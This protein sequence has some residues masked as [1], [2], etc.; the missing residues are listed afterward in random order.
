VNKKPDRGN[1]LRG[2]AEAQLAR[3]PASAQP[4]PELLHELQVHQ[5]EL[6]MQNESLRQAQIALEKSRDRYVDLY[7]FAPVGFLTATSDGLIAKVNLT[8]TA[9]L[10]QERKKLLNHR[11]DLQ[12]MPEDRDRW[13]RQAKQALQS[14]AKHSC[15]LALKRGDGQVLHALADYQRTEIGDAPALRVALTDISQRRQAEEDLRIAAIAFESEEGMMVADAH[16]VIIRV[17]RAF[18]TLTGFSAQEVLGKTPALLRSD[19]HDKAFYDAMWQALRDK[20]YWQGEVWNRHKNG[21]LC[22]VW[23]TI[24][25]VAAPDGSVSHYVGSFSDIT[26]NKLAADEIFQLAY[27]DPLTHLANRRRLLDRLGQALTNAAETGRLGAILFLD[28][29]NFKT[30]NDTRGHDSGDLLLTE[31]AQRMRASVRAGDTLA[32]LG[33]DEFVVLL[34]NLSAHHGEAA[35]LANQVGQKL[36]QSL[37]QPY[38]LKDFEYHG[39]VSIGVGLFQAQDTVE[40]L[41]K[42]AD[43]ALYQAK[44]AGRNT[45]RFFDP[46]M[47]AALDARSA[48]EADLRQALSRQELRLYYQPQIDRQGRVVGAEA[49]IRWQHPQR[50]LVLPGEFIG[51]A[52]DC[53]LIVPIGLWVLDCACA[54]LRAWQGD[55]LMKTLQL[56]VNV[57]AR[58]F[59]QAD[60]ADQ[61]KAILQ[62]SEAKP[63]LLK[64]ELTESLVLANVADTISKMQA[65]KELGLGFSLDDFGTG[66]SSLSYLAQLPLEQLKIDK[67]FVREL[68]GNH[69]SEIIAQTIV[70]MGQSLGLNVIAEGVETAAQHEFLQQHGCPFYQG[71][72]FSLPLPLAEF[73]RFLQHQLPTG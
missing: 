70:T 3:G 22:A 32:R 38:Q 25:A 17:N 63:A 33:G 73:E 42:H 60:F 39:T 47:Q 20:R 21:E 55:P 16:G 34:E 43:L 19:R 53:G 10:R 56:A 65:L 2:A 4:P 29:D 37:D 26:Q 62:R 31:V 58:Q 68:P 61:V 8:C 66:F 46:A 7:E 44:S 13:Y 48:L 27:F 71:Y 50:G 35:A 12:L 6:E 14:G 11:F 54:Q 64:L 57:S 72:W 49:L 67:S 40:A 18:T 1:S 51:L 23:L 30:L 5:I 59:R 52:E 36:L 28:L 41:L 15:E 24:T 45:L 69:S 9:M